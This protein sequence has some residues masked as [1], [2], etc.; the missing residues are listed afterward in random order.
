MQVTIVRHASAGNKHE[1]T[2]PDR[3]RPLDDTGWADARRLAPLLDC[4]GR[5]QLI[6]SPTRRCE[7]T[8]QPVAELTGLPITTSVAL[9]PTSSWR[10][11]VGRLDDQTFAGTILCTHGE[12]MRPILRVLR[13]RGALI[14]RDPASRA[15][16]LTKGSA[17]ELTIDADSGDIE[18]FRHVMPPT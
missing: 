8:L 9:A 6:S 10:D 13:L 7:Q 1:W 16:L 5:H 3:L 11:L 18:S 2:G 12:L 14:N 15:R 4:S 17:W